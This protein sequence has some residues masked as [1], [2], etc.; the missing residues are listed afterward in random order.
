MSDDETKDFDVE[1]YLETLQ[2]SDDDTLSDV[3]SHTIKEGAIQ[4]LTVPESSNASLSSSQSEVAQIRSIDE[5]LQT[6]FSYLTSL[7]NANTATTETRDSVHPKD[8]IRWAKL[9]KISSQIFSESASNLYGKATCLLAATFIAVGT[10]KGIVL[11]FDHHQTL[12]AVLGP[13]TNAMKCREVT[14]LA[15]SADKT[16]IAVGHTNGHIFTWDLARPSSYNLHVHAITPNGRKK[17]ANGHMVGTPVIH[18]AFV[19]K[20]HSALISGDV[21]G[22]AFTHNAVRTLIGR[23]V[24][25]HRIIGRY[26]QAPQ[27]GIE[28]KPT[29][30]LAC[31]P[32]PNDERTTGSDLCLVAVLT[33]NLLALV[34]VYP[35]PRTE[36]KTGRPKSVVNT[37]GLSGSLAW[38]PAVD[39]QH[40]RLAYSWSNVLT[41]MEVNAVQ[42]HDGV[43]LTFTAPKRYVGTESIVSIQWISD[44]IIA[45]VTITQYLLLINYDT[46]EASA[47]IDLANKHIQ[48]TDYYSRVLQDL[49][50]TDPITNEQTPVV[51]ADTYFNSI[52][53][54]KG[55]LFLMGS[56]ELVFGS[57][58]NW[59]DILLDTMEVGDA[60]GA[61]DLAISYYQGV[62]D[63]L[64]LGLPQEEEERKEAVSK[65]MPEMMIDL[66]RTNVKVRGQPERLSNLTKSCL[67]AWIMIGKPDVLLDALFECFQASTY[68]GVF[69]DELTPLIS[70]GIVTHIGPSIFRDLIKRYAVVPEQQEMLEELICV[71]DV[72]SMDL[73][74]TISLCKEH[75]LKDTLVFVWNH[76]LND[77]ITPLVEFL[78]DIRDKR[79]LDDAV[80]VYPYISYLLTG[81]I[82]PTGQAWENPEDGHMARFY[83]YYFIF[84]ESSISWP[85]EGGRI[86][87]TRLDGAEEPKYPYLLQLAQF[88]C[89]AFFTALNEAFEDSFLNDPDTHMLAQHDQTVAF[90]TPI[91]RQII[92][93]TLLDLY[94]THAESL[95]EK[96]IFLDIFLARNYPK[97]AQFI[98]VPTGLVA[99]VITEVCSCKDPDLKP[100]CELGIEA[101][102][103]VYKPKDLTKTIQLLKSV[104]FYNVLAYIYRSEREYAKLLDV[105]LKLNDGSGAST[106]S[107]GGAEDL[108]G[109]V[110]EGF[111]KGGGETAEMDKVVSKNFRRLAGLDAAR[112]AR[113][114]SK[115]SGKPEQLHDR[116][117][118]SGVGDVTKRVYLEAIKERSE[119]LQAAY[120]KL[121]AQEEEHETTKGQDT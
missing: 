101:L 50:L 13:K 9:R 85:Q 52:K 42:R 17:G 26:P 98:S 46:M 29:T 61:I 7:R 2:L 3:S 71:L 70:K 95:K 88:N 1:A 57:I 108:L 5:R 58:R 15:I 72:K 4:R 105:T 94:D 12:T 75:H 60:C 84:N 87:R 100:E 21:S 56:Y 86:I 96:R 93:D 10:T 6:R 104:R 65:N 31:A 69:F 83:L 92:I 55:K 117:L 41:V 111:K 30:L 47:T 51:T 23:T 28:V 66:I 33:P 43:G 8:P 77:F 18:V 97:Y 22:M 118:T 89:S 45:L 91:S 119:K 24:E 67:N 59:A 54:F 19:G 63:P 73:D 115:Y 34:S 79:D 120:G 109:L 99:R 44:K 112:L 90:G 81:R 103:S 49:T 62:K 32:L 38:L 25:S 16:Y 121:K 36:F 37:M 74:L 40:P 106:D 14:S 27:P 11:V 80:K 53:G 82:Y 20:R 116:A 39:K 35:S 113:M 114:V 64:I 110:S 48:H 107:S 78:E 68:V 76:A 102:L